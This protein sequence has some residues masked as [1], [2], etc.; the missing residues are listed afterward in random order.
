[1]GHIQR[2]LGITRQDLDVLKDSELANLCDL[3][4]VS[5]ALIACA[6]RLAWSSDIAKCLVGAVMTIEDC[7]PV[8]SE[9]K[10][11]Y[12]AIADI[13]SDCLALAVHLTDRRA[14]QEARVK[15][16]ERR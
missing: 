5:K 13:L 14:G 11:T 3:Q 1:M 15:L 2:V 10:H 4:N 6:E 8:A 12:R 9:E 7:D 16:T